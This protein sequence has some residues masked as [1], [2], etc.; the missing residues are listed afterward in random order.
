MNGILIGLTLGLV[1]IIGVIIIFNK[2]A[3]HQK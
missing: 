3:K 1:A 2:E